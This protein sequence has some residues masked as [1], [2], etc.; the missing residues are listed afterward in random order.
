MEYR[1]Q[2]KM[3]IRDSLILLLCVGTVFLYSGGTYV[4][5]RRRKA[6]RMF[7]VLFFFCVLVRLLLLCWR[8]FFFCVLARLLLLCA[9]APL[10]IDL[11]LDS[12]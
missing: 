9:G 10:S 5:R 1:G 7:G 3:C 6:P 8:A 11:R 4:R 12:R 2:L